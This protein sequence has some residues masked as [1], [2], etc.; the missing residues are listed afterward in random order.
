MS[1]RRGATEPSALARAV[2]DVV[3]RLQPGEV[4][5]YGEV[6]R[7]AGCAGA[8]RAVGSVLAA[9]GDDVP[10]WRVVRADGRLGAPDERLQQRRLESEGVDVVRGRVV[11]GV[12]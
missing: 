5:S 8:A 4:L 12:P 10:W 3:R 6:A 11:G 7:R 9:Q 1:D 2:L